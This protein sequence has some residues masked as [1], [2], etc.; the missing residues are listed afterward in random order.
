MLSVKEETAA[1]GSNRRGEWQARRL[2]TSLTGPQ[3]ALSPITHE[4]AQ[5][6]PSIPLSVQQNELAPC[7]CDGSDPLPP[8]TQTPSLP[9]TAAQTTIAAMPSRLAQVR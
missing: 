8:K 4:D 2:K 1:P 5:E 3:S 9:S 6:T 7:A